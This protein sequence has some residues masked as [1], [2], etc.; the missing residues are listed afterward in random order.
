MFAKNRFQEGFTKCFGTL[1]DYGSYG[2][3]EEKLQ[4]VYDPKVS[5]L[6][7]SHKKYNNAIEA[8]KLDV[9]AKRNS[10]LNSTSQTSLFG[11]HADILTQSFFFFQWRGKP[12]M[13]ITVRRNPII[14]GGQQFFGVEKRHLWTDISCD[15]MGNPNNS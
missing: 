1:I 12:R 9:Q 2:I 4:L 13:L 10:L 14:I 6:D 11:S 15:K 3:L 8:T 5:K 7:I